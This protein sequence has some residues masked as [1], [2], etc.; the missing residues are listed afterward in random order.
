M[1]VQACA[2]AA[3][4]PELQGYRAAVRGDRAATDRFYSDFFRVNE[5]AEVGAA[6]RH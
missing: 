5:A 6:A 4:P 2:L 3:F 1:T